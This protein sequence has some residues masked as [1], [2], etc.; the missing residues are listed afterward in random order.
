MDVF[1][2]IIWMG[3]YGFYKSKSNFYLVC[4]AILYISLRDMNYFAF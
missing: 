1:V 3:I 4:W 2:G